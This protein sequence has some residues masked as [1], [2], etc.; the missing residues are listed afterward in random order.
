V[1]TLEL[2]EQIRVRASLMTSTC[3]QMLDAIGQ[4]M[5]QVSRWLVGD[6]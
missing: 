6:N 2:F 4:L 3:V 1:V 5:W